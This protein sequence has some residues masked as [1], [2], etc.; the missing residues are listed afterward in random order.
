MICV[1]ERIKSRTTNQDRKYIRA[2]VM[3]AQSCLS[4]FGLFTGLPFK[5]FG[6]PYNAFTYPFYYLS[7]PFTALSYPFMDF[8]QPFKFSAIH[9][10]GYVKRL[11]ALVIHLLS[12]Y[13]YFS[14]P[15]NGKVLVSVF[16]FMVTN[17]KFCKI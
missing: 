8:G 3:P 11:N 7:Q 17:I 5:D 10:K 1:W 15:F 13:S 16:L 14:C 2:S 9:L 6:Q 12:V 4:S